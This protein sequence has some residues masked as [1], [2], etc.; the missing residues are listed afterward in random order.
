MKK[1]FYLGGLARD[2]RQLEAVRSS[3]VF[4]FYRREAFKLR[5]FE[6]AGTET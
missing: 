2:R 4:K 1:V 3:R 6:I 5:S